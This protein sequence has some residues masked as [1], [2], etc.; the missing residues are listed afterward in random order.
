MGLRHVTSQALPI[1]TL[2]PW[3]WLWSWSQLQMPLL[4]WLLLLLF[5][6]KLQKSGAWEILEAEQRYT[7]EG[8][9]GPQK[10]HSG[11]LVPTTSYNMSQANAC[12]MIC[13]LPVKLM[14]AISVFGRGVLPGLFHS[15][16]GII[17][18]PYDS[19]LGGISLPYHSFPGGYIILVPFF[20]QGIF[21]S[22]IIT[23]LGNIS[24]PFH[25]F[26]WWYIIPI[27][28]FSWAI[29]HFMSLFSLAIYHS[30]IIIF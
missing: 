24:F 12:M 16:P 28:L 20:S 14:R 22:C 26:P 18:F 27:S 2:L 19:F 13:M 30:H 21:H 23:F 5:V 29:F 1:Y 4:L 8:F 10:C 9:L 3:S 15:L 11:A 6:V 17:S 25:Y 7:L